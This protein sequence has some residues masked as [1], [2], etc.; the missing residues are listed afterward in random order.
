MLGLIPFYVRLFIYFIANGVNPGYV[1]NEVDIATF[2]LILH[3][4]NINELQNISLDNLRKWKLTS[5]GI[6]V[7]FIIVLGGILFGSYLAAATN[8]NIINKENLKTCS[9]YLSLFSLIFSYSIFNRI[10]KIQG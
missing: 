4:S 10:N 7:V 2:G 5:T 6:T 8:T 9:I 3:I 1:L